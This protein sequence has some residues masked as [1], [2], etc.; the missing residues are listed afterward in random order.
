MKT[1]HGNLLQ[2]YFKS[3]TISSKVYKPILSLFISKGIHGFMI[4]MKTAAFGHVFGYCFQTSHWES[5][6]VGDSPENIRLSPSKP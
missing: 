5:V 1:L 2:K 3:K 4:R 6:L